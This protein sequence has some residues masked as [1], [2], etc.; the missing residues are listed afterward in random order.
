MGEEG[1]KKQLGRVSHTLI[2]GGGKKNPQIWG[3]SHLDGSQEAETKPMMPDTEKLDA[4]RHRAAQRSIEARSV[5]S[6]KSR[7][8]TDLRLWG[9]R[10]R[11]M[12]SGVGCAISKQIR[13]TQRRAACVRPMSNNGQRKAE[14]GGLSID[15]GN[16]QSCN[17][18][19]LKVSS[20]S[21]SQST[22]LLPPTYGSFLSNP[23]EH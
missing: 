2:V 6:W 21:V 8:R 5:P 11:M 1:P 14:R 17:G 10:E 23:I 16:G 19:V 18:M 22:V 7:M 12:T 9:E 4:S 20:C 3:T 15:D 13:C